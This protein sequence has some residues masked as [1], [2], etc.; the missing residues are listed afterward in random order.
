M[1]NTDGELD[2]EN[3][4]N[5]YGDEILR[6]CTLY[7]RDFHLAEDI[8]QDTFIKAY[9]NY[10]YFKHDCSIKTWITQIA[11]NNCK[12]Q[13]KGKWFRRIINTKDYE[14]IT[15]QI[16]SRQDVQEEVIEHENN[17]LNE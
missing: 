5:E 14:E 7:V 11:I 4:M 13:L 8:V 1:N 6:L 2:L 3:V 17:R 12:N 16:I 10:R 9:R 15:N